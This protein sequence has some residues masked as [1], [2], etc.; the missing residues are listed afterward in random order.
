MHV[1]E[2]SLVETLK[3]KETQIIAQNFLISE[4]NAIKNSQYQE[5][6]ETNKH[7]E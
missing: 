3:D 2:Q 4:L 1:V 6:M 5:F 7:N